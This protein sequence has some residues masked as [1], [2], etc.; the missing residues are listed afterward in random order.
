MRSKLIAVP[1]ICWG[2][3]WLFLENFNAYHPNHP[4]STSLHTTECKR[5]CEDACKLGTSHQNTGDNVF[6]WQID[7][8]LPTFSYQIH[9]IVLDAGHGG[10]D[11][12]CS[13]AVGTEKENNLEIVLRLGAMIQDNYPEVE[14]IYTRSTD[15]FVPLH[16]RAQIANDANADLFI[17]VHCNQIS[18]QRVAG[19]ETYIMGLHTANSNLE[20]MKRENSAILLEKDYKENYDGYDPNSAEAHIMGSM[21]QSNNME[22][23]LLFASYVQKRAVEQANRL[24]RGVK[25]AG[26]LVLR[27]TSMPS[28]LVETG[29]LSNHDED[30]YLQ[31]DIGRQSMSNAIF[32][33]FRD[34]KTH[35]EAGGQGVVAPVKLPERAP[36]KSPVKPQKTALQ[37]QKATEA[38]AKTIYTIFLQKSSTILKTKEGNFAALGGV[39]SVKR[40]S[41]YYYYV[42]KFDGEKEAK[43]LL[44][45]IQNLGF[46]D[47]KVEPVH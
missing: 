9:K 1:T 32:L 8:Q 43:N 44:P 10:K 14:V 46:K 30:A 25:Q 16:E 19:T 47:A 38:A 21:F 40:G 20:V 26:F 4:R 34:Y 42:G 35:M 41:T 3:A 5:E 36:K 33:A 31:S 18:V 37:E 23:S 39:R 24:D 11:P 13:G 27:A 29:Y 15:I 17:S 45:D 28:V 2:V 22:Q 7:W 6:L 12:G